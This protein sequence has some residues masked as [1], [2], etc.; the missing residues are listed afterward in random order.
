MYCSF[1]INADCCFFLSQTQKELSAFELHF[2]NLCWALDIF[3]FCIKL[4]KLKKWRQ[5][6]SGNRIVRF[7]FLFTIISKPATG[8]YMTLQA[9]VG[10][11]CNYLCHSSCFSFHSALCGVVTQNNDLFMPFLWDTEQYYY[12]G[13]GKI[14][15]N[16]LVLDSVVV[17]DML[18]WNLSIAITQQKITEFCCF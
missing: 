15:L 1:A 5:I 12:F 18:M 2:K 4:V 16:E 8:N 3:F 17:I 9:R 10:Y 6:R 11:S 13:R 14:F 7:Y